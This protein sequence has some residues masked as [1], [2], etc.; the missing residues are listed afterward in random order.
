MAAVFG[1][2]KMPEPMPT[3]ESQSAD[4][5]IR[6]M[7]LE[8]R[9]ARDADRSDEHPDRGER[10]RTVPVR[11]DAREGRGDEHPDRERGE[12][13]PGHDRRLALRALKVED[14]EEHAERSGRSR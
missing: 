8:R 12:L 14:E 13:E 2:L 10:A 9:H 4:Q 11:R 7:S 5:R 6:R 3:S 1:L